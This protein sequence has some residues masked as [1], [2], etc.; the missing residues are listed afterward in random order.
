MSVKLQLNND[1]EP[2]LCC[3]RCNDPVTLRNGII[4]GERHPKRLF[5]MDPTLYH[6]EC[7]HDL[8]DIHGPCYEYCDL[9]KLIVSLLK[10]V[11]VSEAKMAD[12][13]EDQQQGWYRKWV[14]EKEMA[15]NERWAG[16]DIDE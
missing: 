4:A 14:A 1:D 9:S 16:E 6:K 15:E 8:I 11:A 2:Y 12:A 3:A 5:M 10:G 13:I 7:L